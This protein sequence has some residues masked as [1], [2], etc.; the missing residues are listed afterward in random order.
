MKTIALDSGNQPIDNGAKRTRE[1]WRRWGEKRL[2]DTDRKLGFVCVVGLFGD[3]KYYRVN[4][5]AQPINPRIRRN[6]SVVKY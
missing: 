6:G 2:S 3:G 1:Q 4:Y 5:G